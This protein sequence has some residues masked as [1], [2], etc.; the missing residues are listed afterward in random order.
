MRILINASNIKAGGAIQVADSICG[1][2]DK[3]THTQFYV[4]LSPQLEEISN[5][6]STYGNVRSFVYE[7]KHTPWVFITGRN[8][9]LDEI[10]EKFAVDAVLT[11]F[12]PSLWIPRVPHLCGFARAHILRL[13]TPY[14][15]NISLSE[16]LR[17]IALR[18]SFQRC[19]D[20]Y[21][22]ENARI[23]ELLQHSI[24]GKTVFT[25]TNTFNQV[26]DSPSKFEP[27]YLP[28]FDGTTLLTVTAYYSH[29]NIKIIPEVA[30]KLKSLHPD[31]KFRFVITVPEGL[32]GD[33]ADVKEN[34]LCI[35]PV[36]V[37]KCPSLYSQAQI[38]FQPTL[39]ECFSATYPEAMKMGVPIVTTDLDFIRSICADAAEYYSPLDETSA[40][41]AVYAVSSNTALRQ[42]LIEKGGKRL[43]DFLSAQD[44]CELLISIVKDI[45]GCRHSEQLF[46]LIRLSGGKIGEMSEIPTVKQWNALASMC[47]KQA[48]AAFCF[49]GAS[50]YKE[51]LPQN[52]YLKWMSFA[53]NTQR[54][55]II[56]NNN[57][58]HLFEFLS[59]KGVRSF[60]MKGQGNALIYP[61]GQIRQPG[62]ID[63]FVEGG[64]KA[65]IALSKTI[66]PVSNINELELHLGLFTDCDVEIHYR[67]FILRD[68]R[69]NRILQAFFERHLAGCYS[70]VK[71]LGGGVAAFA[72][73]EFNL[74]HQLVHISH[75][76]F[77]EGVGLRQLMDYQYVLEKA[78]DENIDFSDVLATVKKL[79]LERFASA[80]MWVLK[81]V[82]GASDEIFLWKPDCKD[83]KFLL[84]EVLRVGNFGLAEG[85]GSF[86]LKGKIE[87]FFAVHLKTFRFYRFDHRAWFFSPL[88]RI[89]H[90]FLKKFYN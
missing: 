36:P 51:Y 87:R 76:L 58:A 33:I 27:F 78:K 24:K 60:I 84:K 62:D 21:W 14:L 55:N 61:D 73:T 66:A 26:F 59:G 50:I 11:V 56:H 5:R 19:S 72:T 22:V 81:E 28:K 77:T 37:Y 40:A 30:R 71:G 1:Y 75:H 10:V 34:I 9:F 41:E 57:C 29:K 8:A 17:N 25:V 38:M 35:G 53:A 90:F 63:V 6:I 4:V 46:E 44:R 79:N 86:I 70:N 7:L 43:E 42:M 18:L 49:N 16:R 88:W 45:S 65:V 47:R 67:P 85:K 74:V 15:K 39:L 89:S 12:G 23:G 82:F 64:K 80:L 3:Y 69:R 54:T 32:L 48:I 20:Y 83:G 31:L 13:D 68:F 52:L 2:L